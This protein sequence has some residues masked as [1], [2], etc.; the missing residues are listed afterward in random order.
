MIGE[1]VATIHVRAVTQTSRHVN[2]RIIPPVP[3]ENMEI[4]VYCFLFY[5][6]CE[7][8]RVFLSNNSVLT[9]ESK[10]PKKKFVYIRQRQT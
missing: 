2:V 4:I 7:K 8:P 1:D 5:V 6:L 3:G 10:E 9:D